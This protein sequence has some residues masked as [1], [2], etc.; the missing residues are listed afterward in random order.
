[1]NFFPEQAASDLLQKKYQSFLAPS[2]KITLSFYKDKDGFWLKGLVG[3]EK[4]AHEFML[5]TADEDF[6]LLVDYLDGVLEEF[7]KSE[8][9]AFLSLD[10]SKRVFEDKTLWA[11]Q[12]LRNFEAEELAKIWLG[13]S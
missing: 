5:V 7:F 10:L 2:E 12:E 4:K 11:K 1:M 13:L 6:D 3:T 8:R 9:E